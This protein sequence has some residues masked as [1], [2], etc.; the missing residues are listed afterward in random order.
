MRAGLDQELA[1][2]FDG[3]DIDVKADPPPEKIRKPNHVGDRPIS[4]I[5]EEEES[6]V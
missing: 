1:D 5:A 4:S 2:E 3:P 6:V